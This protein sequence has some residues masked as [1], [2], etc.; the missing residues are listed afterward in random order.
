MKKRGHRGNG[1]WGVE[2]LLTLSEDIVQ[3]LLDHINQRTDIL[4]GYELRMVWNDTQVRIMPE[5]P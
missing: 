3:P 2:E 4:P 1:Y 5:V